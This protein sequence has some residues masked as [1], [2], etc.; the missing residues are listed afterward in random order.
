MATKKKPAPNAGMEAAMRQ[1]GK[2]MAGSDLITQGDLDALLASLNG[3]SPTDGLSDAD[4][5]ARDA[6][7]KL[8]FDAME[9]ETEEQAYKLAKRALSKDPDCVDALVVLAE[10]ESDSPRKMI[11]ALQ[12][13][14]AAG[15][16]SLGAAFIRAN[17]GHFWNI[18]ETRPYMRALAQLAGLLRGMGLNLEAI[19]HYEDMLALNPNDNQGVRDPLL[20]LY[21]GTGNL[22]GARKLLKKYERDSSANFAWLACW[23]VSSPAIW[24]ARRQR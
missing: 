12:K 3:P 9:A 5:D 18:I 10:I 23:S 16:R 14:V 2:L 1:L 20:G 11:E 21:L 8:A 13:A 22:E 6:A 7:Q 24:P 15:E 19:K 4:A 17:K